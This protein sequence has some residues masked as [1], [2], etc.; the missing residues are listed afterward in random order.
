MKETIIAYSRV[1]KS[2]R[3]QLHEKY[4]VV[5]FRNGEYLDNSR[6]VQTLKEAIGIIGLELPVTQKLLD[7]APKLKIVSNVSVGYD[8]LDIDALTARNI[9]ATNTPDI[10]TDTVADAVLGIMLATARRIPELNNFVKNGQWK[11]YLQFDQ[12]GIDVHHKTVGIIGMGSIGEAI[13]KRCRL[14]FDMD[15]LYYN[16]S[17]K[18]VVEEK[19]D[20]VYCNL[21]E[22]LNSSD[23]VVLMVPATSETEKMIG[24]HAFQQMKQ[25]S[26]FING[27]RGKNIDE[28]A[29]YDALITQQI[30]AAGLDVF[31]SEPV[32]PKNPLLRLNNV[33]T[34]PHIGAA[35]VENELAMST[36]AAQNLNIGIEG[37][38]PTHLI[39]PAVFNIDFP[40]K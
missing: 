20:A 19:Y 4:N 12:F 18:P 31:E 27:S 8:N 37:K 17:R 21:N 40:K 5:Y 25:S 16:R 23:F 33:V 2:V 11:E 30:A 15:V 14:G 10:L 38:R 3:E 39:N 28:Q 35:T 36:L 7:L 1:S 32:D 29:L 9:M 13:T 24:Q 6:F 34:L 26:I 22:L